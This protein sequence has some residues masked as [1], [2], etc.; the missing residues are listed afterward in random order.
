MKV[1]ILRFSSLG[2]VILTMPVALALKKEYP[3]AH[4]DLG[5]KLEYRDLFTPPSPFAKVVYLDDKGTI[6]F[7]R[8]VNEQGYD[9]VADLHASLR[10]VAI[11]PFLKA[12]SRKRYK[13]GT[14]AR[15][16][17]VKSGLKISS[18]PSV[19][20]RYMDI[21]GF[22]DIPETPWFPISRK[23]R[24]TGYHIL[25]DA[26][27]DKEIIVGIAPGAKWDTKKWDIGRYIELARNFG[28][29]SFDAVFVFGKG[30]EKDRE[31]LM[32]QAPDLKALDTSNY[33]LREIGYAISMMD[34]FVS[35]DTGLM[36]LAEAAGTPVVAMFG[37][38]TK[39][40][41]FFPKSAKSIVIEKSLPCRPC[42]LHGS[43]VCIY[44]H[45]RC[46]DNITVDEVEFAVSRLLKLAPRPGF[47]I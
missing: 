13:K 22:K 2:D 26:G 37:P 14:F 47:E 27:V 46:M 23:D 15:R 7:A 35:G 8:K 31:A 39:E 19:I 16:V 36:H 45:H 9:I 29:E 25:K 12:G 10:T 30:D 32:A 42:S 40:F 6:P 17:L 28:R 20:E 34:V 24:N 4:V 11:T 33:L 18:F 3:D 38:T 41:G 5:T 1:L 43:N 21:F 44:S